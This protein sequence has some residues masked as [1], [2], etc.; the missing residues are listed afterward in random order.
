MTKWIWRDLI[1]D[2]CKTH[3]LWLESGEL[4]T[5]RQL[6]AANPAELYALLS[7]ISGITDSGEGQA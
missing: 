1:L 4:I 2:G 3:G 6:A 7:E 5:L